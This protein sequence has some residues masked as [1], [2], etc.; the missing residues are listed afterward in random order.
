MRLPVVI[1]EADV[2]GRVNVLRDRALALPF[3]G[4]SAVVRLTEHELRERRPRGLTYERLEDVVHVWAEL[5]REELYRRLRAI[6]E[7]DTY[8]RVDVAPDIATVAL[9]FAIAPGRG[10]EPA[11]FGFA[12]LGD[13]DHPSQS[14]W[15]HVC[16]KTQYASVLGDEHLLRCHGSLV[17]LLDAAGQLGFEVTVRDET[18]YWESRDPQ[19]LVAAVT[20]MNRLVAKFGGQ[21]TDAMRDSAGDSRQVQGAIFDHPDFERLETGE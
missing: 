2:A 14:W 20:S 8:T 11:T 15:W 7:E 6:P 13:A 1:P 12:R 5:V 3:E 10:S 9:G 19:Q 21:F 4:V 17:A 18:G 16:C